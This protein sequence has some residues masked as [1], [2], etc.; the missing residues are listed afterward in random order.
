[1]KN[2]ILV[3]ALALATGTQS[4]ADNHPVPGG[5]QPG[6]EEGT[7]NEPAPGQDEPAPAPTPDE[8]M[9][10]PGKGQPNRGKGPDMPAPGKGEPGMNNGHHGS[11]HYSCRLDGEMRG[12]KLGWGLG[13]QY[14]S[15]KGA[16]TC[17]DIR[18]GQP[19][20]I[21]MPVKVRIIGG[22]IGFD[23]T[24]VRSMKFT[25][26]G[27]GYVHSPMDLT[28]SFS[29]GKSAGVTLI[30]RGY[31]INSA[32]SVK[33]HGK[34]LAFELGFAGEKAYGLGARLHGTVMTVRPL[35][36]NERD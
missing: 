24:I 4:F 7:G 12:L 27:L 6:Q 32:I 25:S 29:V 10:A 35:R 2:I 17:V 30:K 20:K 26:G 23:F 34:G 5:E 15:G 28:G 21:H 11:L 16:I 3:L 36:P 33:K 31:S 14:M 18:H 13:G 19:R 8:P 22:G 1:M 9:P